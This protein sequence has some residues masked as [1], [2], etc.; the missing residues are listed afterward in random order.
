[1]VKTRITSPS[2]AKT[3]AV[4]RRDR[5]LGVVAA[6]EERVLVE[7]E[8]DEDLVELVMASGIVG[9]ARGPHQ[10][11]EPTARR[12]VEHHA[13]T[14]VAHQFECLEVLPAFRRR[15]PP[16]RAVE[17]GVDRR[18]VAP[19][20]EGHPERWCDRESFADLDSRAEW[21][22]RAGDRQ[23]QHVV[24]HPLAREAPES[25]IVGET[26]H[27][28]KRVVDRSVTVSRGGAERDEARTQGVGAG[29][30]MTTQVAGVF[31]CA[32]N[33]VRTRVTHVGLARDVGERPRP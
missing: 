32:G 33:G 13:I 6:G 17:V 23:H 29:A 14:P 9:C 1:M 8:F 15:K 7:R 21:L 31:Q 4:M 16:A 30:G 12:G 28:R 25:Q 5:I 24:P 20:D 3:G 26:F 19:R 10:R 18:G 22:R 27:F 2:G 11:D